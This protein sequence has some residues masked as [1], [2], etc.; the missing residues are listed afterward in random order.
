MNVHKVS[1]GTALSGT[2]VEAKSSTH[3]AAFD[4]G[5]NL[6]T[7]STGA[8]GN[9]TFTL[10]NTAGTPGT[11]R[12][13]LTARGRFFG[14]ECPRSVIVTKTWQQVAIAC[15]CALS[16]AEA[17]VGDPVDATFTVT[18]SGDAAAENVV[19]SLTP[20][21]GLAIADGTVFPLTIGTVGAGQTARRTVRFTAVAEGSQTVAWTA[22]SPSGGA[23]TSCGCAVEV[24]KGNLEV[25]CSCE[26]GTFSVGDPYQVVA[27]V[28]NTGRG[29][30]RN[31]TVHL[32][33]PEGVTPGTQDTV[34][35]PE[36]RRTARRPTNSSSRARP[37][38]PGASSTR[39]ASWPTA[40]PRRRA[41]A[42]AQVVQ[43]RLEA[44]LICPGRIGFAE[45]GNFTVK[46]V[47]AGDGP[48]N[49]CALRITNGACLDQPVID[50]P[51]GNLAA[52]QT[53]AYDWVA[54]GK[55][56]A[57]QMLAEATCQGCTARAECEVEVVGLPAIQ[58]EM[59]D[60]DLAGNKAGVFKVG[61]DF[62]YVLYVQNDIEV[63]DPPLRVVLTLPRARV[64]VGRE[65]PERGGHRC[66][67]D[68]AVGRLPPRRER[69][70]HLPV[71]RAREGGPARQLARNPRRD[72][73]RVRRRRAR[74]RD[75]EHHGPVARRGGGRG[76]RRPRRDR[77]P[78][79]GGEC[80]GG[81]MRVVRALVFLVLAPLLTGLA[82]AAS[83]PACSSTP[84]GAGSRTPSPASGA[85]RCS[86]PGARLA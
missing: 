77:R 15:H 35:L 57:M 48:A 54:T 19:L 68:R 59:T 61:D 85:G 18:N 27:T 20:P 50:V 7:L 21:P 76:A 78:R 24:V 3:P 33:W 30:L 39:C 38:A 46:V 31:V 6:A 4:G 52:G 74:E 11:N 69:E 79:E 5:G 2:V 17:D 66:R 34:T 13:R 70:G 65:R 36:S 1:D 80:R 86:P 72:P 75:R 73:A 40:R 43:C 16:V 45:P 67:P 62:L 44:Q 12:V 49:G 42:S 14:Q 51:I 63:G 60:K 82:F 58:S 41:P 56:N 22:T 81:R 29:R 37:R 64:R 23:T 71:P 47:N 10:R 53:F 25:L 26:P 84:A 9:A 32:V 55:N 8:D 28:R 83:A